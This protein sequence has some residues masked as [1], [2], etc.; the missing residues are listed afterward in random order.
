M[1]RLGRADEQRTDQEDDAQDRG[2]YDKLAVKAF[3]R[4]IDEIKES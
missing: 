4:L 1:P 2:R 3:V